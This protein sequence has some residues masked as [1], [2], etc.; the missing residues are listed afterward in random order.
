M[1]YHFADFEEDDKLFDWFF[2]A[3]CSK[4]I[5]SFSIWWPF[6]ELKWMLV[7]AFTVHIFFALFICSRIPFVCLL[8]DFTEVYSYLWMAVY[9]LAIG[10]EKVQRNLS[11][12]I[13]SICA[14]QYW[15]NHDKVFLQG[16]IKIL[17]ILTNFIAMIMTFP[18]PDPPL[19][20]DVIWRCLVTYLIRFPSHLHYYY[21][22]SIP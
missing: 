21:C 14:L 10:E 20:I 3:T 13:P 4:L 9:F 8:N 7:K 15:Y 22:F 17:S 5:P 11:G 18:S 19:A 16:D 1:N 2:S 6:S 12:I